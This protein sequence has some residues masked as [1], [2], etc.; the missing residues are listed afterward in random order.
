MSA[1]HAA[2]IETKAAPADLSSLTSMLQARWKGGPSAGEKKQDG[3][4]VGQVRSFRIAKLD[5][6][7]KAIELE[8]T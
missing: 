5:A 8:V 1:A 7:S 3:V 2:T 6:D 4:Y